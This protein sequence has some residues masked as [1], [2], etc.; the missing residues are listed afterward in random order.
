MKIKPAI[1]W[2]RKW[3]TARLAN[4]LYKHEVKTMEALKLFLCQVDIRLI[5]TCGTETVREAYK[6]AGIKLEKHPRLY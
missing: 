5:R 3:I 6:V 1:L 4:I 2:E